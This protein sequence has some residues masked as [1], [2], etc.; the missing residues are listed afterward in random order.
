MT[1]V[2][3]SNREPEQVSWTKENNVIEVSATNEFR[4]AEYSDF[5]KYILQPLNVLHG[6]KQAW[7]FIKHIVLKNVF[8]FS[9]AETEKET[10]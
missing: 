4:L 2:I 5:L 9:E 1:C 6:K 10:W 8:L 3:N 7:I